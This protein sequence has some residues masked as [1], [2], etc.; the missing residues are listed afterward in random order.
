MNY[1]FGN[2]Y[3]GNLTELKIGSS[4]KHGG[5]FKADVS[6]L[7]LRGNFPE[8]KYSKN[9]FRLSSDFFLNPDMG[10]IGLL[11]FDDDSNEMGINLRFKWRISPG[12]IIYLVYNKNWERVWDPSARFQMINDLGI[13]KLQF[14][15]RP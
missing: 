3:S 15:I 9:L 4:Y 5:N 14:S 7:F 13:F 12:N 6:V 2:F 1:T 11:Q 10:L 8:G